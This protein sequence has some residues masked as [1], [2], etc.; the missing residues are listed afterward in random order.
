MKGGGTVN[1]KTRRK[2]AFSSPN[3]VNVLAIAVV[4]VFCICIVVLL[5]KSLFASNSK[6]VPAGL[7]TGTVPNTDTTVAAPLPAGESTSS[8][9]ADT[10]DNSGG[11]IP[12]IVTTTTTAA[13]QTVENT[14]ELYVNKYVQ[15]LAEPKEDAAHVICMSPNV[16]LTV[17]ERRADGYY[18]VTFKNYDGTVCTGYVKP[19]CLS[20]APVQR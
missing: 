11:D 1:E 14:D 19:E 16:K 17:L 20:I 6:D 3:F 13:A 9:P 8:K 10:P 2:S 5:A 15:L 4:T 18:K 7:N 12:A